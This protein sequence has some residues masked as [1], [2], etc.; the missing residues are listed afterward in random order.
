MFRSIGY[1]SRPLDS[2][3]PFDEDAAVVPNNSGRVEGHPGNYF[4]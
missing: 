3:T 2:D 1:K 4:V